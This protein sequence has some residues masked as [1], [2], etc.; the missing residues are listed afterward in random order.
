MEKW[1]DEL[2]D[3]LKANVNL[4]KYDSM[5]AALRGGIE[6]QSRIGRSIVVPND[7]S[8]ADEMKQYY[9]RL[10]QTANG[11]LVMHPDSA[12]GD[13]SAEFWSQLGVPEESKGYH[14]P[15]DM[16]MQNEVV[17]SV[18][19]MAKKAGL[20]DKQFQ[21]QIAILNEQSVEQAAQ[22]EQ[23][24]ADDAAIVTSKFGLAEPARKTAIEALVSKFADPDH[25]LGELN[26]AA[27]LM[28]NN[29]VEAFT[30]KGPQVF[31]QPS[32]DTAMSPDE[33][34]DEIAKIDK[35]LMKDGY[36]EGHKRLIRK[37]VKLL[38]MRQ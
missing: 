38:E 22:F 19:D 13:H 24:R 27:Y 32:G 21:A 5:E 1:Q 2:P 15:E 3:D 34:D 26:A 30:G 31:N 36:G 37:K 29:I 23:L 4:S 8:D 6:A 35:T 25:P 16:T 9:D 11:K 33:I 28:L 17:E 7:D 14:T 12:E 10:Q 20:T 18:R